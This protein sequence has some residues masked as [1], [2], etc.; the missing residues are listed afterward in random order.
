MADFIADGLYHDN[1][2]GGPSISIT[3]TTA[4]QTLIQASD[5]DPSV[6]G[7]QAAPFTRQSSTI[8]SAATS[9]A[10]TL[11]YPAASPGIYRCLNLSQTYLRGSST[12]P[13]Q[14]VSDCSARDARNSEQSIYHQRTSS[15]SSHH[16]SMAHHAN[17]IGVGNTTSASEHVGMDSLHENQ[18]SSSSR[19][20][21]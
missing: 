6:S 19:Y 4:L 20:I 12:F 17:V 5:D 3:N 1:N 8:E 7:G 11:P 21:H 14:N 18:L 13:S 16:L 15:H 10:D 2:G 9:P